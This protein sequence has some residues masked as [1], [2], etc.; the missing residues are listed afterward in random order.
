MEWN[1]S[2]RRSDHMGMECDS[3]REEVS[4]RL[5]GEDEPELRA[6]VDQH[7]DE[8]AQCRSWADS[9][10]RVTRLARTSVAS[11]T[12][13]MT[14]LAAANVGRLRGGRGR[15]RLRV[16]LG[17]LGLALIAIG[18]AQLVIGSGHHGDG[19]GLAHYIGEFAAWNVALG[20]GFGWIAVRNWRPAGIVPMLTAFVALLTAFEV[21]DYI[22]GSVGLERAASHM[23]VQ[24]GWVI[25]LLLAYGGS[26][27]DGWFARVMRR[28]GRDPISDGTA[29][30]DGTASWVTAP[31]VDPGFSVSAHR[32]A[33]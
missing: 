2:A 23:P 7:L 16:A 21:I 12:P 13:D 5:D 3:C 25:V 11:F 27:N 28:R 22:Q 14:G 29:R 8:C 30:S 10:A 33:A 1:F 20:V 31:T 15:A 9:A 19:T 26:G 24:I 18:V 4:A 17:L 32:D 6:S